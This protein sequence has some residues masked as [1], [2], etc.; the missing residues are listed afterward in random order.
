MVLLA[1]R[2]HPS[3]EGT[4]AQGQTDVRRAGWVVSTAVSL[5]RESCAFLW[6]TPKLSSFPAYLA[7]GS[8]YAE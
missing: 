3:M 7:R 1:L 5:H 8:G 4:E 6:V 2:N